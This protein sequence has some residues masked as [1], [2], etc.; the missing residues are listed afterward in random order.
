MLF[1][2]KKKK[3]GLLRGV[4]GEMQ[5]PLKAYPLALRKRILDAT[6]GNPDLS[7][8]DVAKMYSV[9]PTFVCKLVRMW[10]EEKSWACI[11]PLVH[12]ET[13]EEKLGPEIWAAIEVWCAKKPK[14]TLY[15]YQA[16]IFAHFGLEVSLSTIW[17]AFS[18]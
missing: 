11:A 17:Q 3:F 18:K 6:K 14:T 8:H 4:G 13:R 15:E 12:V 7:Y 16:L 2:T 5:E 9:S 1:T 10:D